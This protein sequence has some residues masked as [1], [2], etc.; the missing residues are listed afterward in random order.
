MNHIEQKV[1]NQTESQKINIY[2]NK[3]LE[4]KNQLKTNQCDH[5]VN[6]QREKQK[7]IHH[8]VSLRNKKLRIINQI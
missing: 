4:N 3:T 8:H 1:K 6:N 7:C 2:N 5:K